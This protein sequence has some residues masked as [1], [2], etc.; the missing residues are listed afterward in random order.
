MIALA[1]APTLQRQLDIIADIDRK[2]LIFNS[3]IGHLDPRIYREQQTDKRHAEP[4]AEQFAPEQ[5]A[6]PLL[7]AKRPDAQYQQRQVQNTDEQN[8][9]PQVGQ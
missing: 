1:E 3:E 4:R 7:D 8:R 9:R 5:A 2:N 6:E